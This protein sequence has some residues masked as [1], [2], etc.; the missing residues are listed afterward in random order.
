MGLG[1][2]NTLDPAVK[3]KRKVLVSGIVCLLVFMFPSLDYAQTFVDENMIQ[4]LH[5]DYDMQ[6][7]Q[8]GIVLKNL[9]NQLEAKE[10]N[11]QLR[12]TAVIRENQ[13]LRKTY[14]R[15]WLVYSAHYVVA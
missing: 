11:K 1:N 5:Q 14:W 6:A 12:L 10:V 4:R 9:L 7:G 8:R 13:K 3:L 2:N 15:V